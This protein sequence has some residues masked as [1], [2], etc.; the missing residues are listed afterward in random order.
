MRTKGS[1]LLPAAVQGFDDIGKA[2]QQSQIVLDHSAAADPIGLPQ[3][4]LPRREV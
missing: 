1:V 4:A 2:R 3:Q